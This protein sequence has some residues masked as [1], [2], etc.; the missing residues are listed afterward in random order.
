MNIWELTKKYDVTP[1]KVLGQ[2]FLYDNN[3]IRKMIDNTNLTEEDIVIEIGPGL[4]SLTTELYKHCDKVIAY[5]IDKKLVSVLEDMFFRNDRVVIVN[6]DI[7]KVDI[8]NDLNKYNNMKIIANL[9]YYITTPIIFKFLESNL[10]IN[11]IM[12][13]IQK[14]VADRI[15]AK[16]GTKTYGALS[17][18]VQYFSDPKI[19]MNVSPN[20]FFPQPKVQSS[21]V[22]LDINRTKKESV[23][24][25][26]FFFNFIKFAFGQRRK[27]L[28]NA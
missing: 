16:P 8:G 21:V 26:E 11:Q 4:G 2:N 28:S 15:I 25:K 6:K 23:I 1:K 5:E 12:I 20:C 7:L 3:V 9:P 22:K 17:I 27:T 24:N 10:N 18:A 13:M 19:I 14:E